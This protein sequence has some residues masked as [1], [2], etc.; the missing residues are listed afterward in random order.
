MT[1]GTTLKKFND[2]CREKSD[3]SLLNEITQ[4]IEN[5]DAIQGSGPDAI[6]GSNMEPARHSFNCSGFA[7]GI[8]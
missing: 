4:A 3:T 5:L 1:W 2:L 6:I 8:E 7:E